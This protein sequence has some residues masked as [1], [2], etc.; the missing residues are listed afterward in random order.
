MAA[1][2]LLSRG[3]PWRGEWAWSVDYTLGTTVLTGPL[4]AGAAAL[5]SAGEGRRAL[6]YESTPRG[7]LA[8]VLAAG[9]AAAWVTTVFALTLAAALAATWSVPHGGPVPW[10]VVLVGPLL[11]CW[12]AALGAFTG[13]LAPHLVTGP[14]TAVLAFGIGLLG[15]IGAGPNVLRHGPSTGS[16]AGLTWDGTVLLG[17]VAVL[18]GLG[19]VLTAASVRPIGARPR[20]VAVVA[21]TGVV[22]SGVG[23]ISLGQTGDERFVRSDEAASVCAGVRPVVCVA[24]S[25]RR[26]LDSRSAQ[27]G[28]VATALYDVGAAVPERF[29]QELP[30]QRPSPDHGF[31]ALKPDAN[32]PH[33][34]VTEAAAALTT[35]GGCPQWWAP[36]GPPWRAFA[37]QALLQGWLMRRAGVENLSVL[38]LGRRAESW[39]AASSAAQD[40]WIRTTYAELGSCR[41][42]RLALPWQRQ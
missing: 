4:T 27:M 42:D 32:D 9:W 5:R 25:N 29:D 16:L 39:L 33:T 26:A 12:Y 1:L 6:L 20:W 37:A 18:A 7:W 34:T 28:R 2:V 36:V 8:P 3:A 14:A 24:P 10:T 11:L 35:P 31:F 19:L 21:A 38:G 40:D 17:Q 23:L 13:R 41:L 30:Y 15:A 22:G